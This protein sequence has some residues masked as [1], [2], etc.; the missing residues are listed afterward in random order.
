MDCSKHT[1]ARM[2]ASQWIIATVAILFTVGAVGAETTLPDSAPD[3]VPADHWTGALSA[4]EKVDGLPWIGDVT[5]T[6]PDVLSVGSESYGYADRE[7]TIGLITGAEPPVINVNNW[8][9]GAEQPVTSIKALQLVPDNAAT[10]LQEDTATDALHVAKA[11]AALD[12]CR[13]AATLAA[14]RPD[15]YSLAVR[16]GLRSTSNFSQNTSPTWPNITFYV[17]E[18]YFS[19]RV[20]RK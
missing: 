8:P 6:F 12:Q 7:R 3:A 4:L 1:S 13:Q 17:S 20:F 15:K 11:V 10:A 19:C 18:E 2:M 14:S 16:V 9:T 5:I